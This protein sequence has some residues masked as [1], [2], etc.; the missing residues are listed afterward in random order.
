MLYQIF[1]TIRGITRS[2]VFHE[3]MPSILGII[4]RLDHNRNGGP[5]G[6]NLESFGANGHL[7]FW[8]R[9]R[10]GDLDGYSLEFFCKSLQYGS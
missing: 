3:W 2:I 7:F 1:L 9:H 4:G 5:A 8:F 10:T 6:P